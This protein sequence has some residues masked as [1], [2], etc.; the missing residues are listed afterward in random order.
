MRSRQRSANLAHILLSCLSTPPATRDADRD[1]F[2]C[3]A[4]G[5]RATSHSHTQATIGSSTVT[6]DPRPLR[7]A[8]SDTRQ[9]VMAGAGISAAGY[10]ILF[11]VTVVAAGW[12]DGLS[13]LPLLAVSVACLI[14]FAMAAR[15][16]VHA[17][18][19]VALIAVWIQTHYSLFTLSEFPSPSLLASPAL[20][21][22]ATL[23]LSQRGARAFGVAT[24]VTPWLAAVFGEIGR[25]NGIT[26][27]AIFWLVTHTVAMLVIW[28]IVTRGF[29]VLDRAFL[30]VV[31]KE[32]ALSETINK[33]PDGIIVID[34]DATVEVTNPAAE[35]LLGG[36]GAQ[37]IGQPLA[38]VLDA[39]MTRGNGQAPPAITLEDGDGP[40]A[41]TLERR[42]GSRS[43][44]EVSGRTMDGGRRQ[45]VL[46]DVSERVKVEQARREMEVQLSHAQRLEAVGGLAGGI[47]HD[48]NN[49]LTIVGASAEVLRAEIADERYAPLLDDILAAQ[50]RGATLTRQ[51]LAFARR[52]VVQPRVF[53]LSAQVVSLRLLLQRVVGEQIRIT[54]DVEPDCRILADVGQLEQALVNLVNNASD[55]M[56]EGGSCTVSVTRAVL[57][58]G[59]SWV[60]LRVSDTGSGMDEVTR[61]RAFE[62][63]FTTKPRGRGTGLGLASVHGIASQ[64]GGQVFIESERGR[65][66]AVVLEFPFADE[67][68]VVQTERPLA[69]GD[70]GRATILVAE[71]DD[72]TR[73][74]VARILQRLGYA[75]LLAP[76]GLQALRLAEAHAGEID[77]LITDVMMP[78]LTGPKLVS[79]LHAQQPNIPVLYMSG[80][81]EDAL[82]EVTGLQIET[83]FLAKPFANATL[84]T[85]VAAKLGGPVANH[86]VEA[87]VVRPA[88]LS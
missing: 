73:A 68:I 43:D 36:P 42:D 77:L 33:S 20:L 28:S 25:S 87:P 1:R 64:S 5:W 21:V 22:A 24:I 45:L 18:G 17:G 61:S 67:A 4:A 72:G 30:R 79:R 7:L 35:R 69:A 26:A 13:R 50:D 83:D 46:R 80:Y 62:P 40:Q 12:T 16:R 32:R 23:L 49:I 31:E 66:T 52:E 84:A 27:P 14:G 57:D 29:S 47:A 39:V 8:N 38:R 82:S 86:G 85:R 48:F 37:W 74:V 63:F 41:W 81:P 9:W 75:V 44:V 11:G 88:P 60:R 51:L 70:G 34:A 56:P 54:C 76:D 55:A 10:A 78:G 71:D 65:G 53:D 15:N 19:I 59:E 2:D 6:H 58:T 3:G